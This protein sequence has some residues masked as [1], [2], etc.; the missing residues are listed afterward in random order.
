MCS[1]GSAE[2]KIIFGGRYDERYLRT[3]TDGV[4]DRH[5]SYFEIQG[6]EH[7]ELVLLVWLVV[8]LLKMM[9]VMLLQMLLEQFTRDKAKCNCVCFFGKE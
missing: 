5:Y 8:V 3:Q 9:V 7:F 4:G 6:S 2:L 1:S